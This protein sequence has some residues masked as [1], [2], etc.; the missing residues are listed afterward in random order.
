[1]VWIIA[2]PFVALFV[3][4]AMARMMRGFRDV[5]KLQSRQTP[6]MFD[7]G[8]RKPADEYHDRIWLPLCTSVADAATT[9]L[10][11]PLTPKERRSVW[12]ARSALVLEVALKEI[13]AAQNAHTIAELLAR[14][15][16]GMDR[17]DPTKWC[18]IDIDQ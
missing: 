3:A 2:L 17:P 8:G 18:E 7:S 11:R 16:T 9:L 4:I 12:R 1:M 15:P 10:G 13:R 14:F 5:G 6:M